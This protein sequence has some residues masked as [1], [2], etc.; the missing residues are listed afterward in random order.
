MTT[1]KSC[2]AGVTWSRSRE[3]LLSWP[4]LCPGIGLARRS[5]FLVP[6]GPGPAR[7]TQNA[8]RAL[9]HRNDRPG[10][11]SR[12]RADT[13][14]ELVITSLRTDVTGQARIMWGSEWSPV[15]HW[16]FVCRQALA[17]WPRL[18]S[19]APFSLR[20]QRQTGFQHSIAITTLRRRTCRLAAAV[21]ILRRRLNGTTVE[22]KPDIRVAGASA[23]GQVARR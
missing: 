4:L 15:F 11:V 7:S 3:R 17:P 14:V 10:L 6:G 9:R 18:R 20:R 5:R 22:R 12:R 16:A 19:A 2:S 23:G 13:S 8:K 21:A 1:A